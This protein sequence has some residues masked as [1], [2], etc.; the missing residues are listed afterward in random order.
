MPPEAFN[1]VD[2]MVPAP[3]DAGQRASEMP[4]HLSAAKGADWVCPPPPE[5]RPG[6]TPQ[7]RTR[8][9]LQAPWLGGLRRGGHAN[10]ALASAGRPERP[11]SRPGVGS[12]PGWRLRGQCA[13]VCGQLCA[14]RQAPEGPC[15]R[16][17]GLFIAAPL[18]EELLIVRV[19][20]EWTIC[21]GGVGAGA[22][23][24]P[25]HPG[26]VPQPPPRLPDKGHCSPGHS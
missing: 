6:Q 26:L 18:P 3:P 15:V 16:G 14:R 13:G 2:T 17:W 19:E 11:W 1:R 21:L 23:L 24:C 9:Q 25:R 5:G 7:E 10:S 20:G 12:A 4:Q 22:T 8:T